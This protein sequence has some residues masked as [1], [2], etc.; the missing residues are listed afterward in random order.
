MRQIRVIV[1]I[2]MS[3]IVYFK[4]NNCIKITMLATAFQNIR[5]HATA[6]TLV[7]S[8]W[9]QFKL[10]THKCGVLEQWLAHSTLSQRTQ[11]QILLDISLLY[12]H[13]LAR[14]FNHVCSGQLSLA[15]LQGCWIE[16]PFYYVSPISHLWKMGIYPPTPK[17]VPPLPEC[18]SVEFNMCY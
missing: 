10:C 5:S 15:S 2:I 9:V 8:Q 11:V 4:T 6:A 14:V 7:R 17:V 1:I 16:Y 18:N 13:S 12:V 3:V